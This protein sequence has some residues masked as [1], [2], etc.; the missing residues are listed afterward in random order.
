M[1]ER[2]DRAGVCSGGEAGVK[3]SNRAEGEAEGRERVA[4]EKRLGSFW[5]FGDGKSS[6]W[7]G[8]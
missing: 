6:P 7:F 5:Y 1:G 8:T 3:W 4:M 2:G